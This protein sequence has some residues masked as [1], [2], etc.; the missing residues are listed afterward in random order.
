MKGPGMVMTVHAWLS[1][2]YW[3]VAVLSLVLSPEPFT[4]IMT[5]MIAYT[6][7][8]MENTT[9]RIRVFV[10]YMAASEWIRTGGKGKAG[11]Q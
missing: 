8:A 4:C 1:G 5:P 7:R 11:W 6:L 3:M 2:G 10:G 9:N